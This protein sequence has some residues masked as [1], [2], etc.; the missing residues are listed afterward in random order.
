VAGVVW[1]KGVVCYRVAAGEVLVEL[2]LL[3]GGVALHWAGEPAGLS[4][5]MGVAAVGGLVDA[6]AA[7][8][9]GAAGVGVAAAVWE[10]GGLCVHRNGR[11]ILGT[12]GGRG[13]GVGSHRA[14]K[15]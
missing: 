1:A 2:W 7:Y 8:K 9:R 12:F 3:W 15:G 10:A 4:T 6:A 13:F 5:S 14:E 11:C